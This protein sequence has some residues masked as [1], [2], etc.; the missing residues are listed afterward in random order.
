MQEMNNIPL[1]EEV[2]EQLKTSCEKIKFEKPNLD[3]DDNLKKYVESLE[4]EEAHTR[5]ISLQEHIES[6]IK[7]SLL[8]W[9][10]KYAGNNQVLQQIRTQINNLK[11]YNKNIKI[12]ITNLKNAITNKYDEIT[13]KKDQIDE[14][15]HNIVNSGKVDLKY[16]GKK[17]FIFIAFSIVV[18]FATYIYFLDNQVNLKWSAKTPQNRAM[19]IEKLITD[20]HN[21]GYINYIARTQDNC[22]SKYRDDDGKLDKEKLFENLDY[23]DLSCIEPNLLVNAPTPSIFSIFTINKKLLFLAFSAFLLMMLGKIIA[24]IYEK[25]GYK[26]WIFYTFSALALVVV[27]LTTYVN[28]SLS[29]LDIEKSQIEKTISSLDTKINKIKKDYEKSYEFDEDEP[30]KWKKFTTTVKSQKELQ[31]EESKLPIME[32]NISSYS[33]WVSLLVMLAELAI[34][35]VAW[36]TYSDYIKKKQEKE[37]SGGGYVERLKEE[38]LELESLITE[39]KKEIIVKEANHERA[40]DLSGSLSTLLGSI[41]SNEDIEEILQSHEDSIVAK[42]KAMLKEAVARWRKG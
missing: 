20:Y 14:A 4:F 8:E 13:L 12:E 10:R 3:I 9:K 41:H 35:A 42:G 39:Y 15:E 19:A 30:D 7:P 23:V 28:S 18:A 2:Y 6:T 24:I 25:M 16:E 37:I 5:E 26:N 38:K 33:F 11:N 17:A 29:S 32:K 21:E 36:M 31:E 1:N 27:L 34:G 22:F 40:N